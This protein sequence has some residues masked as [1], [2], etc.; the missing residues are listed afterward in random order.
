MD[1]DT[2][3]KELSSVLIGGLWN[4]DGCVVRDGYLEVGGWAVPP[5]NDRKSVGFT[6]NGHPFDEIEYPFAR[7][8]IEQVLWFSDSAKNSGF[9][10]R[11]KLTDSNSWECLRFQFVSNK[12]NVPFN[13]LHD[14]YYLNPELNGKLPT[15]DAA[16]IRRVHG[17]ESKDTFLMRGFGLYAKLKQLVK[18]NFGR[19]FA[20]FSSILDWGCGSGRVT[21]YFAI[22]DKLNITG[23]DIDLNSIEWCK[24]NL[25]FGTF[26]KIPV[27]PPTQFKSAS[28]DLLL[29][30][31][32]FTHLGE[33]E[34]F[35]WLSELKRIAMKNGVLL[36][37]VLGKTG[38]CRSQLPQRD[39]SA[40]YDRGLLETKID[41]VSLALHGVSPIG[42]APYFVEELGDVY[43]MTYHTEAFIRREWSKYFE[44]VDFLPGYLSNNQ[45]LVVMRT[46]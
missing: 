25:P 21:R 2:Y 22:L 3:V 15:P 37:S 13:A 31:S 44:I 20:D 40:L 12:T 35:L 9:R 11:T 27:Q 46:N 10:C 43:R 1:Y 28:F 42:P 16:L 32:V 8:D 17:T 30:I 23:A 4:I 7:E 5:G 33:R 18:G 38:M 19:E 34:Q 39:V 41:P 24:Q 6:V 29:G 45:D 36:M 14:E 26:H